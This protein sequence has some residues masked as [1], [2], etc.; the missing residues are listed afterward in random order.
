MAAAKSSA[1]VDYTTGYRRGLRRHYHGENF[2]TEAEHAQWIL[3][4]DH[5]QELGEGYRDGFAGLAP[6]GSHGNLGNT[7]AAK[8][9]A[10]NSH[11]H[12][13][14]STEQKAIWVKQAQ[15]KGMK[16]AEWITQKLNDEL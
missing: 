13:R 15:A 3:L 14:V 1:S 9:E 2:G 10:K 11:V 12:M 6:R 16:L 5:R 7:N 8:D 4:C